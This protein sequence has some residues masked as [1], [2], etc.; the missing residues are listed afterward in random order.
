M[1]G[2]GRCFFR[3]FVGR[4]RGVRKEKVK[5]TRASYLDKKRGEGKST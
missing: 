2:F 4:G 1:Q 3:D 5:Q